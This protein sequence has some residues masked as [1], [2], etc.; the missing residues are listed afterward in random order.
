MSITYY[1]EISNNFVATK[2]ILLVT[3]LTTN[4]WAVSA[5]PGMAGIS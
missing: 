1:Y 5:K 2:T 4:M 3:L